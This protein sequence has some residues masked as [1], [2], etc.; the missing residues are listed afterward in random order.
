MRKVGRAEGG[1]MGGSR[2]DGYIGKGW[3]AIELGSFAA[4]KSSSPW[5]W[6]RLC[7]FFPR[8]ECRPGM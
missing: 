6:F 8:G 5:L 7:C 1:R 3:T 2:Y 4:D